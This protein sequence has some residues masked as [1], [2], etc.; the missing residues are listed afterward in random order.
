MYRLLYR[1]VHYTCIR[2]CCNDIL[3]R[4]KLDITSSLK[5]SYMYEFEVGVTSAFKLSSE[6]GATT[7][8]W[9]CQAPVKQ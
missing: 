2:R 8:Q 6:P 9:K 7:G 1:H 3:Y 5:G 4:A